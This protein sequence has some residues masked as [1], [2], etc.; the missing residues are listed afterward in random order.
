MMLVERDVL[1]VQVCHRHILSLMKVVVS[2]YSGLLCP[3]SV[4]C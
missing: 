3:V 1:T 2:K 4:A